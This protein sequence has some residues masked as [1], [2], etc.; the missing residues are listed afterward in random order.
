MIKGSDY[1]NAVLN[2]VVAKRAHPSYNHKVYCVVAKQEGP[3]LKRGGLGNGSVSTLT[4]TAK[5]VKIY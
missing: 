5:T 4:L 3:I 1:A 2:Q